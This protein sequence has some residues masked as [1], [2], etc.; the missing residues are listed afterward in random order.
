VTSDRRLERLARLLM[1]VHLRRRSLPDDSRE[2]AVLGIV[3]DETETELRREAQR[4]DAVT[5]DAVRPSDPTR[6]G[7][8]TAN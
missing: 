2:K 7:L 5:A 6:E 1:R 3:E 4:L 8:D